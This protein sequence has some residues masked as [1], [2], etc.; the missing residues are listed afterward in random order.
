LVISRYWPARRLDGLFRAPRFLRP[1]VA[2]AT[3]LMLWKPLR[4]GLLK[5]PL[6]RWLTYDPAADLRST[7][8]VIAE[9]RDAAGTLRRR[10]LRGHAIYPLTGTVLVATAEAML[11]CSHR[12]AGVRAASE[13]F[14]SLEQALDLSGIEE[15]PLSANAAPVTVTAAARAA[16]A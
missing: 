16:L 3:S 6:Q 14:A 2:A 7:V 9:F 5:L 15:V 13:M 11:H 1:I 12:P 4:N 10:Q 8:T